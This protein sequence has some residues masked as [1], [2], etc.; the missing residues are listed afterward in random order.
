MVFK[1]GKL[2]IS[3]ISTKKVCYSVWECRPLKG[4]LLTWYVLAES[5]LL[6]RYNTGKQQKMTMVC[7]CMCLATGRR[8][9]ARSY[10]TLI[11][12]AWINAVFWASMPTVGWAS[13]APDPTGATCTVNWRKN[14]V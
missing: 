10:A 9:T 8:M 14:D 7:D 6:F 2:E 12:A 1:A 13:Y 11:L 4:S 5:H 3:F